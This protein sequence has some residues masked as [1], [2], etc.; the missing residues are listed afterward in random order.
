MIS[1]YILFLFC[2]NQFTNNNEQNMDRMVLVKAI[3]GSGSSF[4]D[5][6]SLLLVYMIHSKHI[7]HVRA[8]ADTFYSDGI[9]IAP[10]LMSSIRSCG[11]RPSMVQPMF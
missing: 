9:S 8:R 2:K 5:L 7:E 6:S 3:F 10:L 1:V 4:V 11:G